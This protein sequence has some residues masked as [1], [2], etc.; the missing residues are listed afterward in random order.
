M[1]TGTSSSESP[2]RAEVAIR[3]DRVA[4]LS[5]DGQLVACRL[6]GG[7]GIIVSRFLA[8]FLAVGDEVDIPESYRSER[9]EIHVQRRRAPRELYQARIGYV[10]QPKQD[11]RGEWF[12]RAEVVDSGL[13]V[14]ALHLSARAVRDYFYAP[15]RKTLN[16]TANLYPL[17]RVA[18]SAS[19]AEIRLAYKV[20]KL[21]L[22][23]GGTSPAA[24]QAIERAFNILG[25]PDLRACHDAQ[26]RA[27]PESLPPVVFPYGGFGLMLVSGELAP[28]RETFF[29]RR[30]ISF[31]PEHRR[32]RF[33][34]PLRRFEFLDGYAVYRD[35][36]R[37][38]EVTLDPIILPLP[39]D[40][41]WNA[42]KHLLGTKIGIDA[43]F[44]R[45]GK[46][47]L[48]SGEWQLVEWEAALPSRVKVTLPTHAQES[49]AEARRT[50]RRFGQFFDE[51]ER[52]R[53]RIQREPVERREIDRLCGLAGMPSDFDIALISWK[54]D[55]DAF[56][57][58]ELR[59]R[60]RKM[61]LFRDEYIFDLEIAV[62]VE[63]PEV[64]HATYLFAR[65]PCIENWV[66]AYAG[67]TKEDV[68]N[69]RGN[70]GQKLG[71][72]GRLM[73][74]TNPRRWL[75][76]LRAKVGEPVDFALATEP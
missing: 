19:P 9:P 59:K 6:A 8:G 72:T 56:Y 39:W 74:G 67:T 60:A 58:R 48:R 34:A 31:L 4:G 22:E 13:G 26:L 23:N 27:E 36:R 33:R 76:D 1:S 11:K 24:L 2:V 3:R 30:I 44:V 41:T 43:T 49:I 51:I 29:V 21:E 10:T 46:Y 53:A 65:P 50:H 63:V 17:L 15:D 35:S 68:R 75:R 25:Q 64:G 66:R 16:Q 40:A 55:Y 28:D 38:A 57:Y 32:R 62:V 69:N 7:T 54:P 20:R 5:Q 47:R 37:K 52:I 12:L 61:F 70:I 42:W 18:P 45:S 71:F 73:H 14:K